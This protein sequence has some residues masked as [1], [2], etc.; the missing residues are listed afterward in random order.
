MTADLFSDGYT[1][2]SAIIII[3]EE[4]EVEE[5]AKL[6]V[7]I[8]QFYD[9]IK[10]GATLEEALAANTDLEEAVEVS[11]DLYQALSDFYDALYVDEIS[12]AE[13]LIEYMSDIEEDLAR[14]VY[15]VV[16]LTVQDYEDIVYEQSYTEVIE[17][18]LD[19]LY[20][21]LAAGL[22]LTEALVENYALTA[23][24]DYSTDLYDAVYDL[25]N[26]IEAG[27]TFE[28]AYAE[29]E[30]ELEEATALAAAYLVLNDID[31]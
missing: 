23:A 18:A 31:F 17:D 15:L 5:T 1:E 19:E 11:T 27:S 7:A 26:A 8:N 22:T 10:G 2:A 12:Y 21:D 20:V 24:I 25:W 6:E 3:L 9:D 13:A 14:A 29:Y 16:D 30:T 28:E 4:L